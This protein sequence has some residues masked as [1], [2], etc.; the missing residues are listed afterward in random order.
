MEQGERI[1]LRASWSSSGV[2]ND[3]SVRSGCA[4]GME[5]TCTP[6]N[7]RFTFS[8]SY[9]YYHTMCIYIGC[10]DG[11]SMFMVKSFSI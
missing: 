5:E 2:A 8:I 9:K 11:L 7:S 10:D 1:S 3:K 4:Y 6:F